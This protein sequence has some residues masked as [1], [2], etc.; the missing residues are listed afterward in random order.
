MAPPEKVAGSY[1]GPATGRPEPPSALDFIKHQIYA[2]EYREGNLTIAKAI[3]MFAV[4]VFFV[5]SGFSSVLI[6][7][8]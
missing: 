8:L 4:G 1:L 5:R 2:P 6:P 7:A 3:G